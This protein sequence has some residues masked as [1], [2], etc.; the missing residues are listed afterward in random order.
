MLGRLNPGVTIEQADAEMKGLASQLREE[1]PDAQIGHT[2]RLMW[3]QDVVIG[4][5]GPFLWVML[6][7]VG[8]VLLIACAN[9][10]S[11]LLVR[12]S[13]REN[14]L[15][16]RVALGAGR[17]ELLCLL[18]TESLLLAVLGGALGVV[19]ARGGLALL[20]AFNPGNIPRVQDIAVDGRVFLFALAV[21][22]LTG[23]LFGLAPGL[24]V[25]RSDLHSPLKD[26]ARSSTGEAKGRL[27]SILVVAEVALSVVLLIGASL[28][29]RSFVQMTRVDPGFDRDRTLSFQVAL[30]DS[31][32][33][34]P[35]FQREFF[36]RLGERLAVLPGVEEA[37]LIDHLPFGGSNMN[38]QFYIEGRVDWIAEQEPLMERRQVRGDYFKALRIPL[39]GGRL[40]TPQDGQGET[41]LFAIIS[42]DARRRYWPSSDP[43]GNRIGFSPTG[44]WYRIVGV[45]GYVKHF[46]LDGDSG[47]TLYLPSEQRS[48][49]VAMKT[50]LDPMSLVN[51]VRT[52]VAA[53]KAD[54]P[55]YNI[56]TMEQRLNRSV[57]APRFYGY[58]F[59][60]FSTLALVMAAVGLYGVISY[61]VSQRTRDIGL[62][63]ALGAR[64]GDVFR[65]VVGKGLTLAL[66]G[67]VLGVAG[68]LG[69]TRLM[70][71]ILFEISP[72]DP[73][74]FVGI[75]VVLVLV[76]M[77]ASYVPAFRA[78]RVDPMVA[79]RHG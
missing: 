32:D 56:R 21:S 30:P 31:T 74:I 17:S 29:I 34:D 25:I 78:T 59:G 54:L 18:L 19:L 4:S 6:A 22:V 9:V 24:R 48:M 37:G 69:L 46:D 62:R 43:I 40:F 23:I 10:A 49:K 70:S 52:E 68:A 63:M 5:V 65:M 20:L 77:L 57:A 50:T 26:G 75:S 14:E 39:V 45:V 38:S 13:R 60:V 36:R 67:V 61:S 3:M 66:V 58:L 64:R 33:G 2:V 76:A 42:E 28:M 53:M 79:L 1:Y 73:S 51:P 71:G 44:P 41:P 27:R 16:I 11:L 15:A 47:P 8:F 72:T 12:A 55:I 35:S 7:A